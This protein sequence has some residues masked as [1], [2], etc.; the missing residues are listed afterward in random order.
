MQALAAT[1]PP[2]GCLYALDPT[3]AARSRLPAPRFYT[4]CGI[5]VESTSS[6]A[7]EME[8]AET[9]YLQNHA[10]VGVGAAPS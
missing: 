9:L 3:P 5:I 2:A 8:G 6:T 10:Q 4:A 1:A 7:F